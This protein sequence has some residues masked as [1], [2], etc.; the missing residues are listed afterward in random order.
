[1][2]GNWLGQQ[3]IQQAIGSFGREY[4]GFKT[5]IHYLTVRDTDAV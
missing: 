2:T 5:P 3:E 4:F 1:M